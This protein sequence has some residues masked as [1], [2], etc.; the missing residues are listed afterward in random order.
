MFCPKEPFTPYGFCIYLLRIVKLS[1]SFQVRV[2]TLQPVTLSCSR[3][4]TT[5]DIILSNSLSIKIIKK[6]CIT[7]PATDPLLVTVQ[8]MYMTSTYRITLPSINLPIHIPGVALHT[9]YPPGIQLATVVFS[10]EPYTSLLLT[11]KCST[12]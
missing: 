9:L 1:C 12:T 6:Q 11:S 5:M 3:F 8:D 7:V 2:V 4:T 10:L